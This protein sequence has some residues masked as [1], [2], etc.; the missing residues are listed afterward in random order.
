[1]YQ[2]WDQNRKFKY[3]KIKDGKNVTSKH[4]GFSQSSGQRDVYNLKCTY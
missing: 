1:M 3:L 2:K 4:V